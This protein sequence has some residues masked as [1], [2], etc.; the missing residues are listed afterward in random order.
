MLRKTLLAPFNPHDCHI[1]AT[2]ADERAKHDK[3]SETV[4]EI[5]RQKKVLP[6]CQG[7]N[8][9]ATSSKGVDFLTSLI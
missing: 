5:G 6:H 4:D 7:L 1:S 2:V 9:G 3:W 8:A